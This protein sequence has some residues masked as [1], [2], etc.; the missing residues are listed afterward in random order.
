[1]FNR[2]TA[3]GIGTS[4]YPSGLLAV[5]ASG[6]PSQVNTY[7]DPTRYAR[8]ISEHGVFVQDKWTPVRKLTVNLGLRFETLYGWINDGASPLCQV[9]TVFIAAQN[10]RLEERRAAHVGDPRRPRERQDG[11]EVLVQPL[12]DH[13]GHLP[14]YGQPD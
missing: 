12:P 10:P 11:A 8:K 9:G 4:N 1:M 5:Y 13:A 2:N 7:N 14:P 3:G 6:V